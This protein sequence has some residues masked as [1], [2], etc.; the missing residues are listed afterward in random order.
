MVVPPGHGSNR[1]QTTR[2][3]LRARNRYDP[4]L[5]LEGEKMAKFTFVLVGLIGVAAL[6]IVVMM[7]W[8]NVSVKI[9]EHL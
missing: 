4:K 1:R 6:I 8:I 3:V 7:Q 9:A 5:R 2:H